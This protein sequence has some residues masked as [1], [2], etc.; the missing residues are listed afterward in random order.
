[1]N[2]LLSFRHSVPALLLLILL[3]ALLPATLAQDDG[4]V[5]ELGTGDLR[6]SYWNG[7]SGS[8]GVTMNEMLTDF[9]ADNPDISVTSEIIPWNTLYAK[10]QAA[11]VA[12]NPPD[13]ILMHA[14]EV[15]QYA[16]YGVVKDLGYLYESGGGWFPDD[17]VS[18]IT[19]EGMQWEGTIYGLPLDNHGRGLW[20]NLDHFEAAGLDPDM[21]QPTTFEG[22]VELFQQLTLDASGNNPTSADF[23]VDNV[24]QW[25]YGV[26]NW[27]LA[28]F[29][30][31]LIQHGGSM[32]SED[33]STIT[34]N[35]EAGIKALSQYHELVYTY[36][37][38]PPA[39]GFDTWGA[40]AAGN[41]AVIPTGTWFRNFAATL[42]DINGQAWTTVQFGEQP[43]TWFGIHTFLLPDSLDGEKLA[44]VER[45]LQWVSDNQVYWAGSG[46]VPARLSA[47]AQLDPVNYPS[48]IVMGQSFT[49]YGFLDFKSTVTQELYAALDPELDAVLNGLK[50]VEDALN[51]GA[52]RMQQ[53]LERAE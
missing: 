10:L 46:Q 19:Y 39:A 15:P 29:L 8:D 43:A 11:F 52:A 48:N 33:G 34:I 40:F 28:D 45:L 37:V 2:Y 36:Q 27:P 42:G 24:V 12:G 21:D 3:F 26:G 13:L 16:S 18:A 53:I 9:V 41:L 51:D 14:S 22:W 4:D 7:L 23:D 35:S 31:L 6:I 50:S 25:A 38:S 30:T 47:Q 5:T 17:D 49:D 32:V 44:A 20:I 1:M